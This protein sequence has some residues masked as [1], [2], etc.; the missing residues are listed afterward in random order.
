[1]SFKNEKLKILLQGRKLRESVANKY[2]LK[3]WLKELK[4]WRQVNKGLQEGLQEGNDKIRTLGMAG[5]KKKN[6]GKNKN[7]GE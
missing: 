7:M 6:N 1:M 2:T 5:G 3:E 4:T